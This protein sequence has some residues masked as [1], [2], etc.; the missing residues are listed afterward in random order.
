MHRKERPQEALRESNQKDDVVGNKCRREEKV[1]DEK[2]RF[3]TLR[4][5]INLTSAKGSSRMGSLGYK[6]QDCQYFSVSVA[7]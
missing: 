2:V 5:M 1:G 6:D 7:A 4:F 3:I